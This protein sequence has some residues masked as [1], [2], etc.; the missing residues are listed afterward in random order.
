MGVRT[1]RD[2]RHAILLRPSAWLSFPSA[3]PPPA[4]PPLVLVPV[5][6]CHRYFISCRLSGCP[7]IE[8]KASDSLAFD[9][10]RLVSIS[11]LVQRT[12]TFGLGGAT[13]GGSLLG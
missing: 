7:W 3:P 11:H 13:S 12:L 8:R 4:L 1:L 10:M 5:C 9:Q 6:A 2:S